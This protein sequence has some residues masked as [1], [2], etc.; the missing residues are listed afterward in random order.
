MPL[1]QHR[2]RKTR[3]SQEPI[4]KQSTLWR[5][6]SI[7]QDFKHML[8]LKS[9]FATKPHISVYHD[10]IIFANPHVFHY[11]FFIMLNRD[12][13]EPKPIAFAIYTR[14]HVDSDFD[15]HPYS[16]IIPG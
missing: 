7:L 9:Q 15:V 10:R 11:A 6:S 8:W 4:H 16:H 1:H 3:L 14:G 2:P 13:L 12:H 5:F